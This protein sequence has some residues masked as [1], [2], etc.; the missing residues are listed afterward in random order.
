MMDEPTCYYC[1]FYIGAPIS[2]YSKEMLRAL[3]K[4]SWMPEASERERELIQE[5]LEDLAYAHICIAEAGPPD[6]HLTDEI[7]DLFKWKSEDDEIGVI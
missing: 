4:N 5:V 3:L 7:C 6:R 2:E 1:K